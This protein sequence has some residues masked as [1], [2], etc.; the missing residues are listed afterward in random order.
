VGALLLVK[1]SKPRVDPAVPPTRWRLGKEGRDLCLPLA[2]ALP[3][4]RPT[5]AV[6]STEPKAVETGRVVAK[7]LAVPFET[8]EDLHE[9]DRSR[10]PHFG[11]PRDLEAALREAFASP[12]DRVLGRE[13]A[14]AARARFSAAVHGV[15]RRHRDGTAVVVSHGTVISLFA[16]HENGAEPMALWSR[17]GLPSYLLLERP[18]FRLLDV[19]S[20]AAGAR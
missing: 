4:H 10:L 12:G 9:I 8:A 11:D 2:D 1:H 18:S 19:W 5:V 6:S 13:S 7:R 17:L 3:A 14:E 20:P 15:L 16:A